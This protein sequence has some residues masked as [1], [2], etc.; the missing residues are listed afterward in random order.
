MNGWTGVLDALLQKQVFDDRLHP[1]FLIA[2]TYL[3]NK[4]GHIFR[5]VLRW[6]PIKMKG[7]ITLQYTAAERY[8]VRA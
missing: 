6:Y 5:C 1:A 3:H 4:K 2:R 7:K 8:D